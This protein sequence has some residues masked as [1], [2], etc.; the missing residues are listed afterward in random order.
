MTVQ[1]YLKTCPIDLIHI[2]AL[3]YPTNKAAN[4]YLSKKLKGDRPFTKADE[5]KAIN[6]LKSIGKDWEKIEGFK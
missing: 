3:M 6:A 2:A 5:T 1:E 4:S